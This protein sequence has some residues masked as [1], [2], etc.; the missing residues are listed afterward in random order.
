MP[1][2]DGWTILQHLKETPRTADIPV[3]VCSVID[4]PQLALTL[5]AAQV[6]NKPF[7]SGALVR[8]IQELLVRADSQA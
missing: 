5:G 8:A 7:T 6:L 4:Q 3:I 1:R 2:R